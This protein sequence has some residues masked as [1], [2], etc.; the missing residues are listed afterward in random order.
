MQKVTKIK[1]EKIFKLQAKIQKLAEEIEKRED[2]V[3]AVDS[4]HVWN[5]N[6]HFNNCFLTS[7]G[8]AER[9]ISQCKRNKE[10]KM[11]SEGND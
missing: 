6:M 3:G 9:I 7:Y 10:E 8:E 11:A 2:I 5:F 4:D 1:L